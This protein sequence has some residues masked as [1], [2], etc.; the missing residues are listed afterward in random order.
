MAYEHSEGVGD[1][2]AATVLLRDGFVTE[3]FI[4]L[5]RTQNRTDA[6]EARLTELKAR[7]A[8]RVMATPAAGCLWVV[9]PSCQ[10][11]SDNVAQVRWPGSSSA[12]LS[13]KGWQ[14]DDWVSGGGV[15]MS[16]RRGQAQ[17]AFSHMPD[18]SRPSVEISFASAM[19]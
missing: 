15:V 8:Q 14:E 17:P 10:P 2:A 12:T 13:L 11:C 9:C 4:D 18:S 19:R 7:L 1:E 3:A 5:A 16:R 6:R